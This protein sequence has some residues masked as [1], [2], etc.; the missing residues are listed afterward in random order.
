MFCSIFA[1]IYQN[2]IYRYELGINCSITDVPH[3]CAVKAGSLGSLQDLDIPL[4]FPSS[5]TLFLAISTYQH[6]VDWHSSSTLVSIKE[7][8]LCQDRLVLG[9]VTCVQVQ[10]PVRDIYLSI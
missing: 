4:E 10:F 8:N 7:V 1:P 5:W 9:W 3:I 6:V 2:L